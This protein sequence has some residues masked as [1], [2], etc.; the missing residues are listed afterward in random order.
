HQEHTVEVRVDDVEPQLIGDLSGH[1][2]PLRP[3]LL[4]NTSTG[5]YR[6]TVAWTTARTSSR[7]RTSPG[8][9]STSRPSSR[10]CLTTS[11]TLSA[12]RAQMKTRMPTRARC[13]VMISP[14]PLVAPVTRATGTV[15]APT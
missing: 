13:F 5:P 11:A 7:E 15:P 2:A 8:Q 14:I 10:S 1:P 9:P 3:A 4:T 6:L 12:L